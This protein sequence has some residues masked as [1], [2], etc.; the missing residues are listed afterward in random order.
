MPWK[1]YSGGVNL[2]T[3]RAPPSRVR[4]PS[5]PLLPPQAPSN[6]YGE[7]SIGKRSISIAYKWQRARGH[8]D[9]YEEILNQRRDELRE[10]D[11]A[12][13]PALLI[14]W[15]ELIGE[16]DAVLRHGFTSKLELAQNGG[17]GKQPS[18]AS[19]FMDLRKQGTEDTPAQ[20]NGQ[21]RGRS[22]SFLNFFMGGGSN[23]TEDSEVKR[24]LRVAQ[25]KQHWEDLKRQA[26]ANNGGHEQHDAWDEQ[27][28]MELERQRRIEAAQVATERARE[29][30]KLR[31]MATLT[32]R[33]VLAQEAM[34]QLKDGQRKIE[35]P[36]RSALSVP[37]KP[38][39][40]S[41]VEKVAKQ[42]AANAKQQSPQQSPA[43]VDS[44]TPP[45]PPYS[46]APVSTEVGNKKSNASFLE[47]LKMV[48]PPSPGRGTDKPSHDASAAL[49]SRSKSMSDMKGRQ[50]SPQE[51]VLSPPE[52]TI[53]VDRE[54]SKVGLDS[55]G[56]VSW[57]AAL[58]ERQ[59]RQ[60]RRQEYERQQRR[61]EQQPPPT[62]QTSNIG[63]QKESPLPMKNTTQKRQSLNEKLRIQ[64]GSKAVR[65]NIPR[66][67]SDNLLSSSQ[68]QTPKRREMHTKNTTSEHVALANRLLKADEMELARK[69]ERANARLRNSVARKLK[70]HSHLSS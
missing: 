25:D 24:L 68:S 8:S 55:S 23:N 3:K 19:S 27:Q 62:P 1:K 33:E 46:K 54:T 66:G 69:R 63:Q 32:A 67:P 4:A 28:R 50:Q 2:P 43:R 17:R 45:S 37:R 15:T 29:Q 39:S 59:S 38:R 60:K 35:S 64:E 7:S 51:Q 18:R 5:T 13:K 41:L 44:R 16:L 31:L 70:Q 47:R 57:D 30:E 42:D 20:D 56:G 40:L 11:L 61:Q 48:A 52:P 34:L 10:E 53:V 6:G 26:H 49:L 22:R 36:T 9:R 14:E 65:D 58:R 12:N 21:R